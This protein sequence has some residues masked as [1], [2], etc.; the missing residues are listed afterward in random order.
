MARH[1][2]DLVPGATAWVTLDH[3]QHGIGSQSCGPGP[4]PQHQLH[5]EP[6]E[7]AFTFSELSD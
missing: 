3:R 1:L 4:L 6:G 5:A 2:T 7:F